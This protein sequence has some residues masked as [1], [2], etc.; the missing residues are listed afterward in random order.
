M[1]P[2]QDFYQTAIAIFLGLLVGGLILEAAQARERH[3]A[4]A[5]GGQALTRRRAFVI[6]ALLVV[7]VLGGFGSLF[8]LAEGPVPKW[9]QWGVSVCL[10]LCF[11][12]VIGLALD[13]VFVQAGLSGKRMAIA[14]VVVLAGG[15]AAVLVVIVGKA[16]TTPS[17][18]PYRVD[19]TCAD[20]DCGLRQHTA[21]TTEAPHRGAKL[22]ADGT[23]IRIRC[24]TIGGPVYLKHGKGASFIWDLLT[25]GRYVSDLF[26]NTT[27]YG[28]FD[29][30]I[31]RCPGSP[32]IPGISEVP[33]R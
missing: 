4:E 16:D 1:D 17:Y 18:G 10:G 27:G 13:F 32:A 12:G 6:V 2:K 31:P 20:L 33:H 3:S 14:G 7:I 9:I 25:N 29:P 22:L 8:D 21:P 15:W 11:L 28:T 23:A 30:V 5:D 19:G 24:Q 26:V